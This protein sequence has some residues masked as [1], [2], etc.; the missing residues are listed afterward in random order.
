MS[1]DK[2][3]ILILN[4]ANCSLTIYVAHA[5]KDNAR[6]LKK[7]YCNC[8]NLRAKRDCLEH[9]HIGVK[10]NE[11]YKIH[12]NILKIIQVYCYQSTDGGGWT[13]F[14]R[15]MD[16]SVDFFRDWENYKHSFGNL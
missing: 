6:S 8:Q 7:Y 16:G 15:R 5:S 3:P 13:V 9:K 4:T 1:C 11:V 10:V 12:Q 14:Q 2:S